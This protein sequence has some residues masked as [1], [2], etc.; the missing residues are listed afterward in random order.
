M[1]SLTEYYLVLKFQRVFFLFFAQMF[2]CYN[3][4]VSFYNR[5]EREV[6]Q[7]DLKTQRLHIAAIVLKKNHPDTDKMYQEHLLGLF[8]GTQRTY[9]STVISHLGKTTAIFQIVQSGH[10][11]ASHMTCVQQL[12]V[13]SLL[14][15]C[16]THCDGTHKGMRHVTVWKHLSCI[17]KYNGIMKYFDV[18]YI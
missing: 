10:N 6:L 13:P 11:Y 17:Q 8:W 3:G 18:K 12:S 5:Q 9:F 1:T 16:S 7:E 14:Q 4:Q 2:K 15:Q